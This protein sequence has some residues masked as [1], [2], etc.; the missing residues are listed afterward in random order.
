MHAEVSQRLTRS[1][2]WRQDVPQQ[3]LLDEQEGEEHAAHR[4]AD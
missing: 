2:H 1:I 3:L 4:G